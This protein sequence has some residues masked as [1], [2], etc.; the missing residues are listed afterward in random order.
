MLPE[1]LQQS[2]NPRYRWN[3]RT[4]PGFHLPAWRDGWP[5][6]ATSTAHGS[7]L[8]LSYSCI[9]SLPLPLNPHFDLGEPTSL[10][11]VGAPH[12][13]EEVTTPYH[14]LRCSAR[15]LWF[16][17]RTC[18]RCKSTPLKEHARYSTTAPAGCLYRESNEHIIFVRDGSRFTL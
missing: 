11:S 13:R 12:G 4:R 6:T 5:W 15:G 7:S 16:R 8:N 3:L 17:R 10:S 9:L 1:G 14:T 18:V 2:V